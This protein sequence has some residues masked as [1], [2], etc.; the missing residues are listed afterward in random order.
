ML[1]R[2]KER[3]WNVYCFMH[4]RTQ[5]AGVIQPSTSSVLQGR[6]AGD[7]IIVCVIAH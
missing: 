4:S 6:K 3:R 7:N 5:S 2:M 1:R